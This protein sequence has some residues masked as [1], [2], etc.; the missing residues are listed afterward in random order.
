M[1][2]LSDQ[3]TL[4]F[5]SGY[6]INLPHA[7]TLIEE[8]CG[9]DPQLRERLQ[10]CQ[11]TATPPTFPLSSHLVI[12]FQRF[13]KYH[14]LLKEILKYTDEDLYGGGLFFNLNKVWSQNQQTL[15]FSFL[16]THTTSQYVLHP[17]WASKESKGQY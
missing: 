9:A 6:C 12:P 14:L 8:M 2:L 1:T 16:F 4:S 7:V 17:L 5:H 10:A 15:F 3:K 11:A 13:L